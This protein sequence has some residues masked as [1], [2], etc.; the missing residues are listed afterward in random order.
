M[1]LTL[2]VC[3]DNLFEYQNHT[4][5]STKASIRDVADRD[6]RPDGTV[7]GNS[8]TPKLVS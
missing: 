4:D 3:L 7:L 6:W 8:M 1:D 5:T 2:S